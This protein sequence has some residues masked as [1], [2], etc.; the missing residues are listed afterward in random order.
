MVYQRKAAEKQAEQGQ[1]HKECE[2]VRVA[3]HVHAV[4]VDLVFSVV[5]VVI[6]EV[7]A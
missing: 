6:S 1:T 2:H 3:E 4:L 7:N 5:H